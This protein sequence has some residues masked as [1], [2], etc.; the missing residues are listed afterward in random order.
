[1]LT[2]DELAKEAAASCPIDALL[3]LLVGEFVDGNRRRVTSSV[4][5]MLLS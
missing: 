5:T 1:M 4:S 2:P 3:L